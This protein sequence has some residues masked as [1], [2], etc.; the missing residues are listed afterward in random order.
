MRLRRV[1]VVLM[2]GLAACARAEAAPTAPTA[3]PP[4]T[5]TPAGPPT[6]APVILSR[7][8]KLRFIEF[9]AGS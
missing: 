2:L 5:V 3:A 1:A 6:A 4:A 7:A 9:F 8:V